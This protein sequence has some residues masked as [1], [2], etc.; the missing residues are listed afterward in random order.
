MSLFSKIYFRKAVYFLLAAG[1]LTTFTISISS[2]SL[3]EEAPP[4]KHTK[5]F[6]HKKPLPKK[7]IVP[8]GKS[9]NIVK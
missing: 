6:Q 5:S 9:K 7:Y 3:L 2:C 4:T 1:I 8:Q